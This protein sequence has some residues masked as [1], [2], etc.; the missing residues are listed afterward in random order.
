MTEPLYVLSTRQPYVNAIL[1]G[2]KKIEFR[3]WETKRRGPFVLHASSAKP[4]CKKCNYTLIRPDDLC[5]CA[6]AA[7]LYDAIRDANPTLSKAKIKLLCERACA[8][9]FVASAHVAVVDLVDCRASAFGEGQS[10]FELANVR[11]L[12]E[13]IECGGKLNFWKAAD[14]HQEALQACVLQEPEVFDDVKPSFVENAKRLVRE[15]KGLRPLTFHRQRS[16]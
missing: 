13:P 1:C 14:E 4:G 3:T 15:W 2:A 8:R 12:K 11:L 7:D 6:G 10:E 5:E 16:D 9:P